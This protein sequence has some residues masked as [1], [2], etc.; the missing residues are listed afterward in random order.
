MPAPFLGPD[1][2]I[3]R[4]DDRDYRVAFEQAEAQVAAAH[5]SIENIDA[6]RDVQQAQISANQACLSRRYRPL[7]RRTFVRRRGGLSRTGPIRPSSL[8]WGYREPRQLE[9]AL[10]QC[11]VRV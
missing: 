6:Q 10:A 4:I 11:R 7:H 5:A 3:A 1:D 2:V 8:C 9:A